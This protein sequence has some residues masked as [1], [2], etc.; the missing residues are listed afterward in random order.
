MIFIH[1]SFNSSR[2]FIL[3]RVTMDLKP[4][5]KTLDVRQEYILDETAVHCKALLTYIFT[6]RDNLE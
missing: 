5:P 3:V 6:N 1:H 4:I 2:C